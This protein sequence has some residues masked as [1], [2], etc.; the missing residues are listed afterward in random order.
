MNGNY[1]VIRS[2]LLTG[3]S[4][5]KGSSLGMTLVAEGGFFFNF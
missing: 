2:R 3:S 4:V 5:Q 1:T